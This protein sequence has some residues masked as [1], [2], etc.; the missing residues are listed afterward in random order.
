MSEFNFTEKDL[1]PIN[2]WCEDK[3]T[4]LPEGEWEIAYFL[5]GYNYA[6]S[7]LQ[8]KLNE[9]QKMRESDNKHLNNCIEDC[10]DI[11]SNLEKRLEDAEA[12]IDYCACRTI[13]AHAKQKR[14]SR[15]MKDN[16]I[17]PSYGRRLLY[18]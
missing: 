13:Y 5:D 7:T 16:N 10:E 1:K 2:K 6:K 18:D 11:I 8:A 17:K 15:Y 4:E 9:I 14:A 3:D 12:V